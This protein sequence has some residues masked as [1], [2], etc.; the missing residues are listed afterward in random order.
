MIGLGKIGR[1]VASRS[2]GFGMKIIGYD[3]LL[4]DEAASKFGF[5]LTALDMLFANSDII[6]LHVPLSAETKHLIST[7]TLQKCK[8]GVKIINCAR[9]GI[10]NENDL[11]EALDSGKVSAAAIDVFEKEPPDFTQRIFNHPKVICTPHLGASTEEAQEKVAIQIAEQI[12]DFFKNKKM[13]GVVNATGLE[14]ISTKRN[15][16]LYQFSRKFR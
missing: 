11:V 13:Y 14:A 9:G 6:T 3:P 1:E 16:T 15:F 4:S 2:K 8:N 10:V 7:E 12:H 5:E